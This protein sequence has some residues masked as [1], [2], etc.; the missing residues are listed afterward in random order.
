M[1][2]PKI[3]LWLQHCGVSST[4]SDHIKPQP[5]LDS[6]LTN[7]NFWLLQQI[8]FL[9]V[10]HTTTSA[11]PHSHHMDYLCTIVGLFG[12]FGISIWYFVVFKLMTFLLLRTFK[13]W[14]WHV[15]QKTLIHDNIVI[16]M[17]VSERLQK[18]YLQK[19][20]ETS[21]RKSHFFNFITNC[22]MLSKKHSN[23]WLT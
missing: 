6:P 12:L 13:L 22:F 15:F 11:Q 20:T 5:R 19:F 23:Y 21:I 10:D 3:W 9:T 4:R 7:I 17:I 1:L 18:I 16:V 14:N 2:S 8:Y